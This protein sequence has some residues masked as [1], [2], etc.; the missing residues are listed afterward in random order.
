MKAPPPS[1]PT[2][3]CLPTETKVIEPDLNEKTI[4]PST[5]LPRVKLVF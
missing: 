3:I 2:N 1:I 5:S 4:L